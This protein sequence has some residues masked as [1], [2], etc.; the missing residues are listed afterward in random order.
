MFVCYSISVVWSY[1]KG[2]AVL[3]VP[4][5]AISTFKRYDDPFASNPQ[6]VVEVVVDFSGEPRDQL[7]RELTHHRVVNC[8]QRFDNQT[9]VG[10]VV[11][12]VLPALPQRQFGCVSGVAL[13]FVG[14]CLLVRVVIVWATKEASNVSTG[15]S[16]ASGRIGVGCSARTT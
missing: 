15:V 13:W 4:A 3:G 1:T 7:A 5:S 6:G 16:S 11:L 14:K 9:A 12:R 2:K 8:V 10:S